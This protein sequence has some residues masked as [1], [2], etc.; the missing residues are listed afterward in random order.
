MMKVIIYK[1]CFGR[2][3]CTMLSGLFIRGDKGWVV[4]AHKTISVS[5]I[6]KLVLQKSQGAWEM[7]FLLMDAYRLIKGK[8]NQFYAN[9]YI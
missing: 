9:V 8:N 1:P 7:I 3:M 6:E 2:V 5:L 4:L